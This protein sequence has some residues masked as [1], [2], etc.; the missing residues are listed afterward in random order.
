MFKRFTH[1]IKYNN[2]TI[3]II[4][5]VFI[6]GASAFASEPG[7]AAIGQKQSDVVGV[8]NSLLLVADL[9]NFDMEFRIEKIEEDDEMYYI[10]YVFMDLTEINYAWQ[11]QLKE[12]VRRVSKKLKQDL[13]AY[14]I[15][16]FKEEYQARLKELTQNKIKTES[17]GPQIRTEVIVYNGLVGKTLD[18]V[19]KVFPGYEPV[20]KTVLDSPIDLSILRT[21]TAGQDDNIISPVEDLEEVYNEYINT[22]D[23]DLDNIFGSADNCPDIYNVDQLDSDGDGLGDICDTNDES[24]SKVDNE[25]VGDSDMIE[26]ASEPEPEI[27][28]NDENLEVEIIDLD[29]M[30]EIPID[31]NQ[32]PSTDDSGG[33]TASV[34]EVPTPPTD[35]SQDTTEPE[36]TS[37]PIPESELEPTPTPEPETPTGE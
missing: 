2:A 6:L 37:E 5:V 3:L 36:P 1:F 11:Y 13:G 24:V 8:D 16:E 22:N 35:L 10:T 29:Q 4:A 23:P 26:P 14:L 25:K 19:S 32:E 15:E 28:F 30:D 33:E 34:E 12:K 31:N 21:E 17:D 20:K 7:R 27:D 9:D 18:I